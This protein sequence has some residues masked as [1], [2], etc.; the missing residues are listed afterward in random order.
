MRQEFRP[1]VGT[2]NL[3]PLTPFSTAAKQ[4]EHIKQCGR[5]H[6]ATPRNVHGSSRVGVPQPIGLKAAVAIAQ[7]VD[8][9]SAISKVDVDVLPRDA[10]LRL[11]QAGP[12]KAVKPSVAFLPKADPPLQAGRLRTRP[13]QPSDSPM[14][15]D[16]EAL[17]DFAP[18][19][20]DTKV[21]LAC[22]HCALTLPRRAR[23]QRRRNAPTC[24]TL[25]GRGPPTEL[26][27]VSSL[28]WPRCVQFHVLC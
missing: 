8:R 12:A 24:P 13:G 3:P 22:P 4:V 7:T 27:I 10:R 21:P 2:T 9:V 26:A 23:K 16:E 25:S 15:A 17:Q 5:L 6:G 28:P 1:A 11:A 18:A 19:R 20:L 14:S